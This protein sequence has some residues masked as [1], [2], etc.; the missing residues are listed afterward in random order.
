MYACAMNVNLTHQ[1]YFALELPLRAEV[2]RNWNP[3]IINEEIG[4]KLIVYRIVGYLL[5]NN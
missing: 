1:L 5:I 2:S 4:S 3:A